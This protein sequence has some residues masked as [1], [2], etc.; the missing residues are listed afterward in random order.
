MVLSEELTD[1][2]VEIFDIENYNAAE[3]RLLTNYWIGQ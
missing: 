2:V 1:E 3:V